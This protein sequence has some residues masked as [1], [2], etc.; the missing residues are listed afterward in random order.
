MANIKISELPVLTG[1]TTGVFIPV[2]N[3]GQTET[4]K[5]SRENLIG[6]SI[7][8]VTNSSGNNT[9]ITLNAS[10]NPTIF[11]LNGS[12][13]IYYSVFTTTVLR[14]GMVD[15]GRDFTCNFEN[16]GLYYLLLEITTPSTPGLTWNV[17]FIGRDNG[18]VFSTVGIIPPSTVYQPT[19]IALASFGSAKLL[20][21]FESTT[22]IIIG[23]LIEIV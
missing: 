10:S 11:M 8:S 23:N 16:T 4:F 21:D 1:Q 13:L 6:A 17:R 9:R 2:I 12:N 19:N 18:T 22:I 14:F 15:V 20:V 5:V 3:S 7:L